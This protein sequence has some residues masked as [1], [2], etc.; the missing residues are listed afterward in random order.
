MKY[1]Q[2]VQ[3][4]GEVWGKTFA[5]ERVPYEQAVHK[6]CVLLFGRHQGLE[7]SLR[8]EP[9][10]LLLYHNTRG[11]VGNPSVLEWL[12]GRPATSPPNWRSL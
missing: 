6:Y 9:E 10:R 2:Y 12:I 7:Q 11:L 8:D 1:T 5:I 3:S 4:I